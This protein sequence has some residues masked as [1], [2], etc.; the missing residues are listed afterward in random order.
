MLGFEKTE[1]NTAVCLLVRCLCGGQLGLACW[2]VELQ[3]IDIQRY[4]CLPKS[5]QYGEPLAT[6]IWMIHPSL[7]QTAGCTKKKSSKYPILP[8][9]IRGEE[10]DYM[11]IVY[12][13]ISQHTLQ[14]GPG[15]GPRL[16]GLSRSSRSVVVQPELV[17][18]VDRLLA[19]IFEVHCH[20]CLELPP[21]HL[22]DFERRRLYL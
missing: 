5:E 6:L 1:T 19:G 3:R 9:L 4:L 14:S 16:L 10:R 2:K 13:T 15:S 22:R 12:E 11:L 17:Q 7:N 20:L 21:T 8:K 18:N